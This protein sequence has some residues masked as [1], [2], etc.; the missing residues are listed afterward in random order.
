M[1]EKNGKS[2]VRKIGSRSDVWN[3]ICFCTS[4]GLE[5]Q[6]LVERNGKLVSKKRS[7]I[8][9]KR[10]Q[11][12]NPFKQPSDSKTDSEPPRAKRPR[13]KRARKKPTLF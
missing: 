11:E 5:K 13:G 9:K 1:Y 10:F 3:E 4:G 2:Y 7:E 12:K 6:H 8:G